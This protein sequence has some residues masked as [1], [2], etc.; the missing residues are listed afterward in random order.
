MDFPPNLVSGPPSHNAVL[1]LVAFGRD[2]KS[3]FRVIATFELLPFAEALHLL[4]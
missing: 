3:F 2:F 4:V 1:S